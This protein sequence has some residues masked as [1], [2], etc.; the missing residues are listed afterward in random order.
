MER[1]LAR[2]ALSLDIADRLRRDILRG[3]LV[4]GQPIKER[5]YAAEMAVSRTPMREAIRLLA[6]EGLVTLRP[7]RSPLVA[8]PSTEEVA[9]ALQ[10]LRALEGLSGELA[11]AA[12]SDAEIAA[13]RAANERFSSMPDDADPLELFERDMEFH[14]A[15][16]GA[17][18]NQ[19]LLETQRAFLA[20]LWRARYQTGRLHRR[21]ARVLREHAAIVEALEARDAARARREIDGHLDDLMDNLADVYE[22]AAPAPVPAGESV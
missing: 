9:C 6:Q 1:P 12:A 8:R 16:A 7:A 4:P 14:I 13:I 22:D 3:R 2:P 17:S 15:I 10:V 5:E 11:C 19:P 21:R 18:H 20:R